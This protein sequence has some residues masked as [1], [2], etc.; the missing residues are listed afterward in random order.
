MY[1]LR[2]GTNVSEVQ[3]RRWAL[4]KQVNVENVHYEF[5]TQ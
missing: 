4:G 3:C 5:E 1:E 2:D